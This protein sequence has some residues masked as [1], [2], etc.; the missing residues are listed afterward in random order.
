MKK[1]SE[2][3]VILESNREIES[4]L[5]SKEAKKALNKLKSLKVSWG[6][7]VYCKR[8][9]SF[10]TGNIE[11]KKAVDNGFSYS[12][13]LGGG[14]NLDEAVIEGFKMLKSAPNTTIVVSPSSPYDRKE[15]VYNKKK[16]KFN[17]K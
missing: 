4:N 6:A 9:E 16:D 3:L 7:V 1:V 8:G 14:K 10:I 5:K 17:L 15:Y 12:Y 13:G 11:L 2:G